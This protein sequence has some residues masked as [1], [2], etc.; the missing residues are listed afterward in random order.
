[1]LCVFAGMK[2]LAFFAPHLA[3]VAVTL[4]LTTAGHV[5]A[6]DYDPLA[7]DPAFHPS[8]VDLTVHDAARDRDIPVRV[9]LPANTE[10]TPV[11]LFSHGLGGTRAGSVFLGE[12]WASRGYVAVFLQHPG[13]DDSVWKDAAPEDFMK[14]M[15]RAV[16]VENFLL[17][18]RDVPAVLDQLKIWNAGKTNSLSGRLDLKRVGMSGHSFGAA[19][20]EAVSGET[21]PVG[22]QSY[23]D[24]R[25]RAAIAFSPSLPRGI[26]AEKAF[27]AVKIPW[28]LMTGTKDVSP[29]G[30]TDLA[31][32]LAVYPALQGIPK[33]EV[34]LNNAEH[35]IFTDRALPGDR[36]PRNPNHHRVI[37]ALSTA[38]WDAY[39]RGDAQALAW[40]NGSGPRS[41]MET[42]D[43]W[44]SSAR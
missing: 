24:P 19:T 5:R 31:S 7:L 20:T 28:M 37:L 25:I 16:S 33:Y 30:N 17:R 15:R 23:T 34:V 38:F 27:G 10:P 6:G 22:G 44:Q 8:H 40:L 41:V 18:V 26:S 1:M 3:M 29:I 21:F 13:S 36:E 32:R 4:I 42:D 9:Y 35:S 14:A 43:Q 12:H 2:R 39:L 11:V